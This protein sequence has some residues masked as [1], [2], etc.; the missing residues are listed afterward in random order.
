MC[1]Q[2]DPAPRPV[3]RLPLTEGKI[4]VYSFGKGE[5]VMICLHG[6]DDHGI[7][8]QKWESTYGDEYTL[9][10]PDLPFH[11]QSTWNRRWMDQVDVISII[12]AILLKIECADYVLTGH[13]YGARLILCAVP[14]FDHLP[15]KVILLAPGGIGTY[16]K[17][18]PLWLQQVLE[19]SLRWPAWLQLGVNVGR[20]LGLISKFH[21]RYAEAQLYP[22]QQRWRLFR[23]FHSLLYFPTDTARIRNFWTT[24]ATA[25]LVV[26]AEK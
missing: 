15:R 13:S 17:V 24:N 22:P 2:P 6:F 19:W 5:K 12:N 3:F 23:V 26:V 8:F 4:V 10:A 25:C 20:K 14:D 21:Q 11:G 9:Y 1:P 7:S 16:D 18:P